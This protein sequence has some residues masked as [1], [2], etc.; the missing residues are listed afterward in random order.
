MA[1]STDP[2]PRSD[3]VQRIS[4][5]VELLPGSCTE[6]VAERMLQIVVEEL[7]SISTEVTA[8][9]VEVRGDL[10]TW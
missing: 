8:V 4:L 2:S 5:R 7:V 6:A 3:D 9:A 1:T 10:A